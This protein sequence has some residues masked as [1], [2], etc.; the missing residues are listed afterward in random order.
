MHV[1]RAG[2]QTVLLKNGKVLV[3]GGTVDDTDKHSKTAELYDPGTGK[4]TLSGSMQSARM[5]GSAT[6]LTSGK[7]LVA[8]GL[9]GREQLT[10]MEIYDPSSGS[11]TLTG[12]MQVIKGTNTA[13]RM[14]NGQVLLIG[15]DFSA[16][17]YDPVSGTSHALN[18]IPESKVK[19]KYSATLLNNGQV[20]FTGGSDTRDWEGKYA[21]AMIYDPMQDKY[22]PTGSMHLSRFKHGNSVVLLEN[23]NVLVAGG[24]EFAELYDPATCEFSEIPGSFNKTL[25]YATA[26]LLQD[27]RVLITGGSEMNIICTKEAWLYRPQ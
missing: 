24:G 10:S 17:V 27:N 6:L 15:S 21:T 22:F 2:H 16:E 13:L 1:P 7:V 12:D 8:G 23:G 4:F 11:F 3:L 25:Q 5:S 26:T 14:K 9:D 18:A 19:Y 20:L